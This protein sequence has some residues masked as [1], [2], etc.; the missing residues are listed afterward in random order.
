MFEKLCVVTDESHIQL[1]QFIKDK[2][3]DHLQSLE[4][5][6]KCY[7]TEPSQEQGPW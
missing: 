2:I 5:E 7:F 1:D 4:K 6:A 3:T